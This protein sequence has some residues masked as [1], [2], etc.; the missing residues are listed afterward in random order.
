MLK[1]GER[2]HLAGLFVT[3]TSSQTDVGE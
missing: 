2:L 3:D 1:M